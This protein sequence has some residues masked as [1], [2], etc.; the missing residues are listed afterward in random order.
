[1]NC[2]YKKNK[3]LAITR[4]S[5]VSFG[6]NT[7]QSLH[8]DLKVL[9]NEVGS[10]VD[11]HCHWLSW[12]LSVQLG[13][14]T[15]RM[16][17]KMSSCQVKLSWNDSRTFERRVHLIVF[18]FYF[19]LVRIRIIPPGRKSIEKKEWTPNVW[20]RATPLQTNFNPSLNRPNNLRNWNM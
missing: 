9:E 2:R 20:M 15:Q 1:M 4:S 17:K 19:T 12:R 11:C 8:S 18:Y 5:V 6:L 7:G 10:S 13:E 16:N 14:W 3:P